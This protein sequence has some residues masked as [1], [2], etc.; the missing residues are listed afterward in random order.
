MWVNTFYE[1]RE[2]MLQYLIDYSFNIFSVAVNEGK[3]IP[4]IH[5]TRWEDLMLSDQNSEPIEKLIHFILEVR[6][7]LYKMIDN[8]LEMTKHPVPKPR[9]ENEMTENEREER[10]TFVHAY[11]LNAA[12]NYIDQNIVS[13]N[14]DY[15]DYVFK[16]LYFKS[17]HRTIAALEIFE[18]TW[19]IYDFLENIE[20][21]KNRIII[22]NNC[23]A[24]VGDEI[25]VDKLYEDQIEIIRKY[26]PFIGK[27]F[28]DA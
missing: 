6:T 11:I 13:L 20:M 14:N 22:E 18:S 16:E 28:C 4:Q 25:D 27:K 23:Y 1:S 3:H 10:N 12:L 17:E 21:I 15:K 26:K 7:D 19:D 24:Y 8:M 5:Q 2:F 9:L